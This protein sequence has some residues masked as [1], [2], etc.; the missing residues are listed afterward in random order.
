MT[1]FGGNSQEKT[2]S[3]REREANSDDRSNFVMVTSIPEDKTP[4]EFIPLN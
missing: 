1:D 3:I 2:A 4:G